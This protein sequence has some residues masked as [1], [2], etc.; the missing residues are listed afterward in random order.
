MKY[1]QKTYCVEIVHSA[2]KV[3]HEAMD[4]ADSRVGGCVL[5]D[6]HQGLPVVIQSLSVF[7][8]GR[9]QGR[10]ERGKDNNYWM[11]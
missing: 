6:E 9:R 10:R 4:V 7:P 11:E 8:V 3:A 1:K 2:F 5:R